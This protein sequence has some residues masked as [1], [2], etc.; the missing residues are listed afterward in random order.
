MTLAKKVLLALAV[1]AT[2][3]IVRTHRI[4]GQR[5]LGHKRV[6]WLRDQEEE[7]ARRKTAARLRAR[8]RT[9]RTRRTQRQSEASPVIDLKKE[10]DVWVA[11]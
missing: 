7:E 3:E 6:R 5:R 4:G 8:Q 10:G 11:T 2:E 9:T 1:V